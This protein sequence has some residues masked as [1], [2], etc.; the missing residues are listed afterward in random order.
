MTI[1]NIQLRKASEAK[2]AKEKAERD[3]HPAVQATE[4]DPTK[5]TEEQIYAQKLENEAHG[6]LNMSEAQKA[7]AEERKE[8]MTYGRYWIWDGYFNDKN[9]QKWLDCAEA[10]KH[11]NDHVLQDIEDYILIKGFGKEKPEKIRQM[12]DDDHKARIAFE[13]NQMEAGPEADEWEQKMNEHIKKRRFMNGIRPPHYW[14][15]FEDGQPE[16]RVKHVLRY[17]ANPNECYEDG[18]VQNIMQLITEIG[19]NL[20]GY[21]EQ[22]WNTM[23]KM[24]HDIFIHDFKQQNE[25]QA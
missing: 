22:K 10:L 12:I 9:K 20:R 16:E 18:R 15:F 17:N 24:V 5:M 4:I 7:A 13:K 25:V 3:G 23:Q 11:V 14:N 21:E 19:I 6:G 2:K 1:R 8:R